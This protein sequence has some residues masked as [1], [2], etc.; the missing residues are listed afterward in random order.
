METM[1]T[2]IL[3]L[4]FNGK[5]DPTT[6]ILFNVVSNERRAGFNEFVSDLS[7]QNINSVDW[8]V[9][10]PASRN[11]VSSPLFHRYCCLFLVL[12]L[13]EKN[14]FSF[15]EII[16]DSKQFGQVL[17]QILKDKSVYDVN[18]LID[19][20]SSYFKRSIVKQLLL[21]PGLFCKILLRFIVVRITRR[22][23]VL[24]ETSRPLVLIDTYMLPA[25]I[26]SDR[27]Y[28][29]LWKN[30]TPEQQN[31]VYFVPTIVITSIWKFFSIYTC[32]RNNERNFLIKEDYLKFTDILYA[33]GVRKR[34]HKLKIAGL[35]VEGYDFSAIVRS[36]LLNNRDM[37]TVL[38]ALL[39]YR[40][41]ERLSKT[42][43]KIRLSIDWFEGQAMDKAWSLGF[44]NFFPESKRVGFRAFESYP[45]YLCSY[46][47]PV[48][49]RAGVIPEVFAVQGK[50]TIPTV[51][52]FFPDVDVIVVPSFRSEHV[53]DISENYSDLNNYNQEVFH[54]LVTLPIKL[55]TGIQIIK[56]LLNVTK[57][58]PIYT[59]QQIKFVFKIHPA[60]TVN[61]EFNNL[62]TNFPPNFYLT[63]EKSFPLLIEKTDLL[64]SEASSTCLEALARGVPV[65][66]IQNK[67]GLTYNPIPSAIP[68]QLYMSVSSAEQLIF[69]IEKYINRTPIQK[70]QQWNSGKW[71]RENYFEPVTQEGVNKLL[72]V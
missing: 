38:E 62:I 9:E 54:V 53:W 35:K 43:I 72:Y 32:L 29:S 70:E 63:K 40:F 14:D 8:W 16:V 45:F 44:N 3:D 64:I 51:Q 22:Q 68:E 20:H 60:S 65:I 28:G 2:N 18:V 71:V 23:Q 7:V 26:N 67:E 55:L 17:S 57:T 15:N 12:K 61:E 34:L 27:W 6:S 49:K 33:F 21:M 30:L 41:I 25:Y 36:E 13:I 66:V 4:R 52:E 39:L 5:L 47:I 11:T 46:P 48:E 69:A 59:Y 1:F 10:G 19:N 56:E 50:G 42:S 58:L 24:K 31:L 37:L